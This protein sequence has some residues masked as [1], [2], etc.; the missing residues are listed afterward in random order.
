MLLFFQR[1]DDEEEKEIVLEL[2]DDEGV[3]R[4]EGG[5]DGDPEIMLLMIKVMMIKV[6]MLMMLMKKVSDDDG[7]LGMKVIL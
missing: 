5:S 1:L 6:K 3:C 4:K 7:Y 2:G